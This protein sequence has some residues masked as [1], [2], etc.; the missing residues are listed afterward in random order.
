LNLI[1]GFG[2]ADDGEILIDGERVHGPGADRGV[3]FQEYALF[4]WLT[5]AQN[6]EFGPAGQGVKGE[7]LRHLVDHY[8]RLVGLEEFGGHYPNRLSGGI[9]QRVALARALA[10]KPRVLLMDE[11][12][13]ALDALTRQILQEELLRIWLKERTTIVFVTHSIRES[14]FL[15]TK[16][17]VM[18]RRPGRVKQ[19]V[20]VPMSYP[21]DT[22]SQEFLQIEREVDKLVREEV[23]K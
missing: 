17:V 15:G 6:I 20:P 5:A 22:S 9:R 16:I 14:V 3:V 19:I 7:D 8:L 4:P 10:N 18:T 12:F 11:P 21:R 23:G 1:A 2:E 13:G